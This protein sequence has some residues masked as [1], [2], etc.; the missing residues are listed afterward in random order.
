MRLV[1][2]E[3]IDKKKID[4]RIG[5]ASFLESYWK[6]YNHAYVGKDRRGIQSFDWMKYEKEGGRE[7]LKNEIIKLHKHVGNCDTS[8]KTLIIGN[9]A[10]QLI[11]ACI[12]AYKKMYHRV[13]PEFTVTAKAPYWFRFPQMC[14]L[15]GVDFK[16]ESGLVPS[17]ELKIITYPSNPEN[18][19]D[20]ETEIENTI[21][22]LCYM[23]P[24]YTEVEKMNKSVM[25]FSL[26]KCTG[27]AGSRIGWAFFKNK[28]IA[29]LVH[30]YIEYDTG[31][32][33]VDAQERAT[34]IL[35]TQNKQYEEGYGHETCF[36]HSKYMLDARWTELE[37]RGF[38]SKKGHRKSGIKILNNS[39]MFAWCQLQKDPKIKLTDYLDKK[40]NLLV[41][42][43]KSSD[44]KSHNCFRL[45]IGCDNETWDKFI[46]AI[47]K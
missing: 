30:Q 43:G 1:S 16:E 32:V 34:Y 44:E 33:S 38:L 23:W 15:M 12:Y 31:G 37:L 41:L 29:D 24:Q 22:D 35:K 46:K 21:Y 2:T 28:K 36:E 7:G 25:I 39:G 9:G 14:D 19:K 45:N 27:H 42:D 40:Y 8:R 6:I 47:S 13:W 5:N 11:M 10:T 3:K 17:S 20:A 26:A 4:M 18:K